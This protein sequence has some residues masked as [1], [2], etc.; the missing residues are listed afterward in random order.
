MRVSVVGLGMIGSSMAWQLRQAEV[1]V[2]GYARRQDTIDKALDQGVIDEGS[3]D[4]ATVVRGADII[5]VAL[6]IELIPR[7]VFQID[8]LLTRKTLV[9]D[10]GSV[11]TY[12]MSQIAARPLAHVDF[13]GGHPM[14]GSEKSGF[15]HY[16]QQLFVGKA[17]IFTY[18]NKHIQAIYE[19]VL[20]TLAHQLQ[21]RYLTMTAL[22][23]DRR[24]S[25]ISH[26]PYLLSV[27]LYNRYAR[28][29][30]ALSA[31]ASTGF[32]GMTRIAHSDPLWGLTVA[33]FNAENVSKDL[34]E[35]IESLQKIKYAVDS[36]DVDFLLT[37]FN[38][39]HEQMNPEKMNLVKNHICG[40]D[41]STI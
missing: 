4:L 18:P 29:K 22:D 13:V 30:D 40:Y 21:A 8:A 14:A 26:L 33:G 9:I 16:V 41:E 11:K 19:G 28:Q 23:H 10:V 2:S 25:A 31:V 20:K 7:M 35:I 5:V 17:F 6:P 38:V 24:V 39:D 12:I 36:R 15:E 27:A 1:T 34:G 32:S 37:C 3:T